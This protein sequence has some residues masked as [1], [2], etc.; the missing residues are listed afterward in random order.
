MH[1]FY[2]PDIDNS[3]YTFGPDESKHAIR[4]LRL[5]NGDTIYL[6]N[7]KG[8]LFQARIIQADTKKCVVQVDNE[9]EHYN[10]RAYHLHIAIA[11]TKNM[12]RFE[13]FLEKVTEI[14][15]D[16]ITP[17]ICDH[18]ERRNLR[19]DRLNKVIE[20]AMKQSLKTYHPYL[21]PLTSF[22]DFVN[23]ES[24]SIKSI[25]ICDERDKK[26][27]KNVCG[28]RDNLRIIIGPEGDF[29]SEE[30]TMALKNGYEPVSLGSSRLRT[31]TA[32]VVACSIINSVFEE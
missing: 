23:E 25:A 2:T 19:N 8:S 16:E 10:K 32:G 22:S 31:E 29:S 3:V 4:V 20:A 26:H 17:L 5:S 21:H 30:V 14:G 27:L 11:P 28:E 9:Y 15:V 12:K 7:G 6:T 24:D 18:S 13:W 1:L